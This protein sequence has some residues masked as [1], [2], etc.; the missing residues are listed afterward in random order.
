MVTYADTSFCQLFLWEIFKTL[1]LKPEEYEAVEMIDDED[2]NGKVQT[3]PDRPLKMRAQ[4][5]FGL[6]QH[7]PKKLSKVINS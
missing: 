4:R 2:E 5:W 3:V 6:K 1:G 7:K